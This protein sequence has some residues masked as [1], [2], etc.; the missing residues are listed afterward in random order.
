MIGDPQQLL[1]LVLGEIAVIVACF[2]PGLRPPLLAPFGCSGRP[3]PPFVKRDS[4]SGGSESQLVSAPRKQVA[5]DNV[6]PCHAYCA[7]E[8]RSACMSS[9]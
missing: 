8:P 3:G 1:R 6:R 5:L 4:G 9:S 7:A 2:H